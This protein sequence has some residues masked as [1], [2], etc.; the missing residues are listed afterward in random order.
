MANLDSSE[1]LPTSDFP[2]DPALLTLSNSVQVPSPSLDPAQVP[3]APPPSNATAT[4]SELEPTRDASGL[5]TTT[6]EEY[7]DKL[8]VSDLLPQSGESN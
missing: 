7:A 4:R 3:A 8:C 6:R 1:R 2:I 5:I